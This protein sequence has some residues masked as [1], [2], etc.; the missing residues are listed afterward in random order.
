[1]QARFPIAGMLAVLIALTAGATGAAQGRDTRVAPQDLLNESDRLAAERTAESFKKAAALYAKALEESRA[2][3]DRREQARARAGL[4]LSHHG[5]HEYHKAIEYY[6]EAAAA[7][8]A[9]GDRRELAATYDRLGEA[10]VS[11]IGS[12]EALE[13]LTRALSLWQ[14]IGDQAGEGRTLTNLGEAYHILGDNNKALEYF[15]RALPLRRNDGATVVLQNIGMIHFYLGDG[16]QAVEYLAE[17]LAEGR[18][19]NDRMLDAHILGNLAR[20]Y[21]SVGERQQALDRY[22]ESLQLWKVVGDRFGEALTLQNI[23][24]TYEEVGQDDQALDRYAQALAIFQT[25]GMTSLQARVLEQIGSLHAASGRNREAL[26]S[27]FRALSLLGTGRDLQRESDTLHSIGRVY[28]GLREYAKATE[29]YRRALSLKQSIGDRRGEAQALHSIGA[30]Y[31]MRGRH[32]TALEYYQRALTL[33]RA[34]GD[35]D[36][37]AATLTAIAHAERARGNLGAAQSA[38]EQALDTIESLRTRLLSRDLRASYAATRQASY[39]LYIEVLMRQHEHST[40]AGFDAMAFEASERARGR[41]LLETLAETRADVRAGVDPVLLERERAIQQALNA[42]EQ[43]RVRLMTAGHT[44]EQAE[45]VE[46]ELR[47]LL[48]DYQQVQAHMRA[49]SPR[50]AALTQ[51]EPLRLREIQAQLDGETLLLEFSLGQQR[52]FVWAVTRDALVSAVLPP[53]AAIERQARR[54]HQLLR[55]GGNRLA[56]GPVKLALAQASG[57]LLGGLAGRLTAKRLLVVPDGALHYVPFGALPMPD[58]RPVDAYAPAAASGFG[59]RTDETSSPLVQTHE[60]VVL[61]SASALAVLDDRPVDGRASRSVAVF[62]DPVFD[63]HDARAASIRRAAGTSTAMSVASDLE[64]AAKDT[65]TMLGRLPFSRR[66]ANAITAMVGAGE[67]FAAVDFDASRATLGALDLSQYRVLHFATHALVNSRHPELSGIVL[68]LVDER[69]RPQD[70]FLRVHEI[71][72][73]KIRADLVVLSACQTALG[74]DVRGEGLVGLTRAFM[75]AGAP[76]VVVSL[77]NVSDQAAAELMTRF[78]RAMFVEGLR[79][80]AALRAAQIALS[81]EPRWQAPYYWAGFVL[82]GNWR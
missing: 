40:G 44:K 14:S 77:W 72:T 32:A 7:W 28:A 46:A 27:L 5:L 38:V 47:S 22:A 65:G 61:P 4:G 74:K 16:R 45:A 39:E 53:R 31:A 60:I 20:A 10:Y 42:K 17:A 21:A 1:M 43:Y 51:P 54:L 8:E 11:S 67:A 12:R 58:V 57:L 49:A 26:P 64:R 36:G 33:R 29:F 30:L 55:T 71:Y 81:R 82:Q 18:T 56:Q 35:G 75:Y 9:L 50:Y 25:L 66:E 52:S 13:P 63:V 73:L 15:H 69:G 59:P 80:P 41:S 78:Y 37:E 68:S 34:A 70:G 19:H 24:R 2:T 3:G 6:R 62:A 23:A 48:A 76:R 79:P